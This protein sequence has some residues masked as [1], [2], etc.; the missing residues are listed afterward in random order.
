MKFAEVFRLATYNG[1]ASDQDMKRII[2]RIW[3]LH[4]E[5]N[6]LDLMDTP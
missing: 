5:A 6:V 1:G 3:R 4:D 2:A